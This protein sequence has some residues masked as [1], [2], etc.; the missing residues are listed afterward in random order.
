MLNV[1]VACRDK[2]I[3]SVDDCALRFQ[4]QPL[5]HSHTHTHPPALLFV[6]PA[7]FVVNPPENDQQQ[8]I[9]SATTTIPPFVPF[10]YFVVSKPFAI[11]RMIRA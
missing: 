8:E 2:A 9:L 6:F 3:P 1:E 5:T 11:I 10:A 4:S 7:L